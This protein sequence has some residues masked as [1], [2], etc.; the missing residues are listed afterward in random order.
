MPNKVET[1]HG[2]VCVGDVELCR[3]WSLVSLSRVRFANMEDDTCGPNFDMPS[4]RD[5]AQI[6][7]CV[8]GFPRNPMRGHT[9]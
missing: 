9:A 4:Q 3:V 1:R 2:S 6:V 5:I 7:G 8:L